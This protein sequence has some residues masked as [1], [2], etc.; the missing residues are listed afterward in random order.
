MVT[1]IG[2]RPPVEKHNC[3]H[4]MVTLRAKEGKSR[5]GMSEL[6]DWAM[7]RISQSIKYL[8]THLVTAG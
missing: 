7:W 3:L 6:T 1:L 2:P 8:H 4:S 5:R